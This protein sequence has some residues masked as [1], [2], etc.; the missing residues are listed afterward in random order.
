M[1]R[2]SSRRTSLAACSDMSPRPSPNSP[3]KVPTGEFVAGFPTARSPGLSHGTGWR[4]WTPPSGHLSPSVLARDILIDGGNSIMWMTSAAQ[5]T[6]QK[7]FITWMSG[8]AVAFGVL[9]RG[10]CPPMIGGETDVE[11]SRPAFRDP[12]PGTRRRSKTP[13]GETRQHLRE[14][15]C[16]GPNGAGHFVKMVHN[17][18]EYGIMQP[19]TPRTGRAQGRQCRKTPEPSMPDDAPPDPADQYESRRRGGGVASAAWS[20]WLARP[21][22]ERACPGSPASQFAGRV[23]DSGE[24]RWTIKAAIDEGVPSP[25]S[26]PLP[27]DA[28]RPG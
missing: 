12:A 16:C 6:R 18:I 5:P 19:H 21:H 24:G 23:S 15:T 9:E 27:N 3:R 2:D 13:G 22:R 20:L 10:Y 11:A 17:G 26:P 25:C 7:A 14:D 8:R 1:V 28:S 4:L